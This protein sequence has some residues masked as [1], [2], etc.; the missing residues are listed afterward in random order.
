MN[1]KVPKIWEDG[2]C[3][4]IGGGTSI[5]KQF[6][7]PVDLVSQVMSKKTTPADY[8]PYLLP[9]HN[10]HVIGVNMAYRLGDWIDMV[11]F[12]DKGFFLKNEKQLSELT[13]IRVSCAPYLN[14]VSW[15]KYVQKDDEKTKGIS[16]RPGKL[17]WNGN[18]GAAAINLAAHTGVR[19]IILLGFDMNADEMNR[20]WW[21]QL[22]KERDIK[23]GQKIFA[24]HLSSF[25]EIAKDAK[26]LGIEILNSNPDSAI[27][28]FKKINI[29]DI[30]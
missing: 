3:Y 29:K 4:I 13:N 17:S 23:K 27:K 6:N 30:L 8:S 19:R 9:L 26:Q 1:W 11:F 24:R 21:H 12:G 28:E 7:I 14:G 22:Y 10:K 20:Q 18:S 2:E 15:V 16:T 25:S 5:I